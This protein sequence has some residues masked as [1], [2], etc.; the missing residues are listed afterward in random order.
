MKYNRQMIKKFTIIVLSILCITYLSSCQANKVVSSKI[1][2]EVEKSEI[3]ELILTTE[4]AIIHIDKDYLT[5]LEMVDL[6]EKIE[7]GIND[8]KN[9]LGDKYIR[10]DVSKE[11]VEY[12]IKKRKDA[13]RSSAFGGD[14]ELIKV[15]EKRSPYVHETVHVLASRNIDT[16]YWLFEGLAVHLQ[17]IFGE[18]PSQPNMGTDIDKL[19]KEILENGVSDDLLTFKNEFAYGGKARGFYILSASLVKYI[20][21]E[22]GKEKL[23]RI[24][25]SEDIGDVTGKSF[26]DIKNGWMEYLKKSAKK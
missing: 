1:D 7:Q 15:K 8:V 18:N 13:G 4:H 9:Y 26:E 12:Y 19:A 23:L 11:K 5:K 17:D 22:Y 20:E 16:K 25:Y 3:Y 6:A 14:I 21:N 24:Y 2:I 10:K